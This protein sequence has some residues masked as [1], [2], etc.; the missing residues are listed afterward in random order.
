MKVNLYY[1]AIHAVAFGIERVPIKERT[2][3]IVC[4]VHS[5]T[6]LRLF[7]L[8]YQERSCAVFRLPSKN[9]LI[10]TL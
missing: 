6:P 4:T 8:N 1:L 3:L 2:D 5:Y 9:M 10:H 7:G